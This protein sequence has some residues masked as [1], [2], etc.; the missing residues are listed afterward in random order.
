MLSVSSCWIASKKL[1]AVNSI[2]AAVLWSLCKFHNNMI[3]NHHPWSDIKQ[4]LWLILKSVKKCRLLFKDHMLIQSITF[5]CR[6]LLCWQHHTCW[7]D[8]TVGSWGSWP[9]RWIGRLLFSVVFVFRCPGEAASSQWCW[10]SGARAPA[11]QGAESG[12]GLHAVACYVVSLLN[13]PVALLSVS[14]C[15]LSV[16]DTC[17]RP[18]TSY[19]WFP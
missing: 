2:Y 15:S 18:D 12:G 19:C 7:T 13:P 3:F 5:A 11:S 6:F 4:V 17:K 9:S 16:F 8:S 14:C 10:S 1:T